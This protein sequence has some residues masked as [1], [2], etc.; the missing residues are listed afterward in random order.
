MAEYLDISGDRYGMLTAIKMHH[1]DKWSEYWECIC[2]CGKEVIRAKATLQKGLS[3]SCGCDRYKRISLSNKKPNKFEIMGDYVVGIT[4]NNEQFI[5]DTEDYDLVSQ[6]TWYK[7]NNGY[8]CHKDNKQYFL[9][10]R[11]IMNPPN[12]LD[13]D[14]INH[15]KSDNRKINLRLASRSQN[16]VNKQYENK[17]GYRGVVELPSGR[18][19][20][21]IGNEYIGSYDTAQQ[22]H[23]AYMEEATKKYG[24]FLYQDNN[25]LVSNNQYAERIS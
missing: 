5:F 4:N 14:H 7:M 21:Q 16:L 6:Y 2:D 18:F 8:F 15:D 23:D 12:E 11:L 13:V 9:L 17:T 25:N 10:H 19:M 24:D 22:A 3:T 20:A 1:K